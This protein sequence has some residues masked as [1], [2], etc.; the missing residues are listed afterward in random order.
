MEPGAQRQWAGPSRTLAGPGTADQGSWGRAAVRKHSA[1]V[2]HNPEG[3]RSSP[4]GTG[5]KMD[6]WWMG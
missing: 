3:Q 5:E 6:G 4:V 2:V 1:G